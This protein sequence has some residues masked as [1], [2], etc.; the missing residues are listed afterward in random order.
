L[1]SILQFYPGVL[2][3]ADKDEIEKLDLTN[4][5]ADNLDGE[6]LSLALVKERT[7]IDPATGGT[8]GGIVNSKRGIYSS[9][10]TFAVLQQQN[11]RTGLRM[12]DM[13]SAHSRAG[14]KFAKMYAAF[15]LGKKLRQFG[16]NAEALKEALENIKSGKLGLS[17]RASTASM[18]K[19][20]EK[21]NDIMLSQTLTQLYTQD[22]QI[23]QGMTM[24]GMPPDLQAYY[25]E[26]LRAKQSLY[27][28][29]VQNF[30]HDDAARLIPVPAV[31]KQGRQ[32]ESNA[33]Q[34]FGGQPQ[35]PQPQP[36]GGNPT[37]NGSQASNQGAIP[38]TSGPV[39]GGVPP[40]AS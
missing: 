36:G 14:S 23:I 7:G 29:I 34:S 6:N 33:Q 28:E 39:S 27:K 16:D 3:P 9:Q 1:H 12:S 20:L 40:G 24:G 8:G 2:V 15:G 35:R 22:A 26:V 31:L 19:E 5:Q 30:G 17:V 32:N 38:T 11:S 4:I 25:I 21:Q 18:N 13:R 37:I 10:G